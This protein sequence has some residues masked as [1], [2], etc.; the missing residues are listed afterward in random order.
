MTGGPH[1]GV[2]ARP[3]HVQLG[4]GGGLTPSGT[5][6][7][8]GTLNRGKTLSRPDR[9]Q[10]PETMFK[11]RKDDEP[12]SCWM[13]CSRITTCWALPPFLKMCGMPDKLVQQA[14][15]EKVTLCVI[16]MLIG[17]M[18]AFLTVGFSFVLCPSE[19]RQG[20]HAFVRYGE[21]QSQ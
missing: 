19:L 15:R 21:P 10:N 16:V 4:G 20:D 13:I 18:V 1:D 2:G 12:A 3:A 5:I 17:G 14:W 9:F 8:T 7:R 11:K 6:R